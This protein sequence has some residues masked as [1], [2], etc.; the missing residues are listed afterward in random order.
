MLRR[1]GNRGHPYIC[2][3]DP[4]LWHIGTMSKQARRAE[5]RRRRELVE[6]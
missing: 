5:R 3:C 6:R 2:P 4:T 1:T